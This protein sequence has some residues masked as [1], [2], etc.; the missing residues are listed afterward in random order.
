MISQP[1]AEAG[2]PVAYKAAILV[3]A[4]DLPEKVKTFVGTVVWQKETVT[5]GQDQPI[6]DAIRA[7]IDVPEANVHLVV[8]IRRNT[9]AQ[10]PASHTIEL[11][12]SVAADSPLG[13]VKQ[14]NV[15]QMREEDR[16][17]G[18][19]L[20]GIPVTIADN[21]FLV[22]LTRGDN[23]PRN[24]ELLR[25][26]GWIDIPMLLASGKASKITFEKGASGTRVFDEVLDGWKNAQN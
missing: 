18:D 24:L 13:N 15:P 9:E 16:P 17:T 12:Y 25:S 10:L 20:A 14:I 5:Q 23:E 19:P 11:K 1:P 8:E 2:I 7:D 6:G 3:D 22:G 21:Y 26:R 4:P